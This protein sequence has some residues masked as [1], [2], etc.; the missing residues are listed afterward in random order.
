MIS[1]SLELSSEWK[2]VG[3]PPFLAPRYLS[4]FAGGATVKGNES[5]PSL[6]FFTL[7]LFDDDVVVK[8]NGF[9]E[10]DFIKAR[11][12]VGVGVDP[13]LLSHWTCA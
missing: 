4:I 1:K 5:D 12:V 7:G 11:L 6:G 2:D 9:V 10:L 3:A 13:P 8:L